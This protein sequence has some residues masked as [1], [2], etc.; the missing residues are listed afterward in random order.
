[1]VLGHGHHGLARLYGFRLFGYC[2]HRI[3]TRTLSAWPVSPSASAS[4]MV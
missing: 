2:T 3:L 4:A 1:M